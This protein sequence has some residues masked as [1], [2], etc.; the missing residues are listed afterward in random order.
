MHKVNIV[1]CNLYFDINKTQGTTC[2]V[3]MYTHEG[4][5]EG[6]VA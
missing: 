5:S 3:T 1:K 2:M 6:Q 4:K